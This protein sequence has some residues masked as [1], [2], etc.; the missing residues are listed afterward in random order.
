M[1]RKIVNEAAMQQKNE[2]KWNEWE[3]KIKMQHNM[4]MTTFTTQRFRFEIEMCTQK[5]N[6]LHAVDFHF[7]SLELLG[8]PDV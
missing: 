5:M 7:I 1:M 8:Y 3:P 2:M 6:W 4:M